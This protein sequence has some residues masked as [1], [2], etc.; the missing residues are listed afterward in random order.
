MR[1]IILALI[2]AS[3]TSSLSAQ[4]VIV[5]TH[6][7]GASYAQSASVPYTMIDLSHPASADGTVTS[8]SVK[9]AGASCT[10]AFKVKFLRPASVST[11]TTFTLVAE[12]GPF[13]AISGRNQL[14]L[15]PP[16]DIHAGDLIA[17]TTLVTFAT[18]GSPYSVIDPGAAAMRMSG[19]VTT[20]SFNGLY[21]RDQSLS[22]RA[23]DTIEVLEGVL[24]AAGSLSGNFGSFFRT[25]VQIASPGGGTS[26]GKLIFHPAGVA[27]SPN[28]QTFPYT[29][30]HGIA[31]S[32]T[33]IVQQMGKSGLGTIDVV[34]N[35]GFP[36]LVTARIYN[37]TLNGTSG[38][39]EDMITPGAA[40]RV[41]D[42]GVLL[43]PPDLTKFRVN[44][45]VRTFS[46]PVTINVQYGF[47]TQSDMDF[48]AN[49]FRQY[50]LTEFGDTSPVENEQII[51]SVAAGSAIVYLSTTDNQTND[52]SVQF[53]RRN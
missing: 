17:V 23:T 31:I 15:T 53:A 41:G 35:N 28:D 1:T 32:F 47:R 8:A 6:S 25:S 39:T 45:G 40:L 21:L 7:L 12:R 3:V 30:A 11:L 34:S 46:S 38:F 9:W 26:T 43:T 19:D 5:G 36:P 29:V 52:S 33:D 18:C 2:L 49:T 13:N 27:A 10:A 51:L 42:T 44:I 20:G 50:S 22:A 24:T 4:N 48:P 37:D 16:V 14:T